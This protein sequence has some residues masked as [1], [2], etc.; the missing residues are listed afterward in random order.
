MEEDRTFNAFLEFFRKNMERTHVY[1]LNVRR[2][3]EFQE[4]YQNLTE[5]VLSK[6]PGSRITYEL[7]DINDGSGSISVETDELVFF[8]I[9][10]FYSAIKNAN[11]LDISPLTTGNIRMT[12]GFYGVLKNLMV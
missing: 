8:N 6:N 9:P 4:C 1:V 7:N 2:Y 3:K 12:L 5:M 11:N 10:K